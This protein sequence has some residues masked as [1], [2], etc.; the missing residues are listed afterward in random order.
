MAQVMMFAIA[1][2]SGESSGMQTLYRDLL[3]WVS[4]LVATMVVGYSARP[5]F[6]GALR[7]LRLRAPG[8]DVPVA[9][10]IGAAYL[11][12]V[13][14]TVRGN[15]VV[16]FDSVCMFTFFLGLGRFLE[17]RIRHRA[18]TRQ[19]GLLG[20]LPEVARRVE[21]T[22]ESGMV[23]LRA[24]EVGDLI[25]VRPG[26]T[27]PADGLVEEG[28]STADE[29]VL[30]GEAAP[31][32][33]GPRSPVIGGSQNIWGPLRIRVGRTGAESTLSR[34]QALLERAQLEK[35]ASVRMAD[36]LARYFVVGVIGVSAAT[37]LAWWHVAPDDAFWIVL[38]VLVATCPCALSLA[39]P[40]AAA[41]ASN[42]LAGAGFL[43]GRG[44]V[45]E[46]LARS[47]HVVFDKTGT[48]TDASLGL[49]RVVPL[50]GVSTSE[51]VALARLLES[52][53][54][55][56]IAAAFTEP[57]DQTEEAAASAHFET[58]RFQVSELEA[59]PQRGRRGADRWQ[60][61]P[62]RSRAVGLDPLSAR[63]VRQA[64]RAAGGRRELDPAGR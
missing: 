12:S 24:I 27:I 21:A 26:E 62:T 44:H 20:R 64:R 60:S 45:L 36:R 40:A 59:V 56:P 61:L 38:S 16:Y 55:H 4:L 35:P 2:Y 22:G 25:E 6:E 18:E 15:G 39:T 9:L 47:T 43:A 19:R 54:E 42:A 8:M 11:A 29:S 52:R 48:L 1:L 41:A 17:M 28:E 3:R 14:A 53:S 13:V 34:I 37:G 30:T 7:D 51:V 10:A 63:P 49:A 32:A 5:F 31:R 58:L 57:G 23:P 46:G 33:K 50:R